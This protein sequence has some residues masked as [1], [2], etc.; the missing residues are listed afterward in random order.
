MGRARGVGLS[1]SIRLAQPND[2]LGIAQVMHDVGGF[3]AIQG[4]TPEQTA[5][6]V[7]SHLQ[8]KQN[9]PN[10]TN[11]VAVEGQTVLGYCAVH[12]LQYLLH[13][14]PT[15]YVTELFLHSS[16]RGQ[17][18][19]GVLLDWVI[20]EAKERNCIRLELINMRDKESYQRRF[21]TKQGWQEQTE[22][23]RFLY[24]L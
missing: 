19:G 22:A 17:G 23:A 3:S 1:Y 8:A 2:A 16:A 15:G 10:Y 14:Q 18:I 7:K 4:Q 5:V 21:Y 13:K 20:K 9:D 24:K 11:Y 12:W 6:F